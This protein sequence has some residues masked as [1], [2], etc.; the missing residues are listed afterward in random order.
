D[1]AT[2]RLVLGICDKPEFE[3]VHIPIGPVIFGDIVAKTQ[4]V[5]KPSTGDRLIQ[6]V[7]QEVTD[8][9]GHLLARV[10]GL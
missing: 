8:S 2:R 9:H 1:P 3:L 6:F 7:F 10:S 4:E 5:S